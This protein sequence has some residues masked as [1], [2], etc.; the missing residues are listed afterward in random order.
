MTK[1]KKKP[2][3]QEPLTPPN[4]TGIVTD[5]ETGKGLCGLGVHLW[6]KQGN[7]FQYRVARI[8][9]DK[10]GGFE[11]SVVVDSDWITEFVTDGFPDLYL[12]VFNGD[13]LVGCA[14]RTWESTVEGADVSIELEGVTPNPEDCEEDGDAD[15][16]DDE[17]DN[18]DD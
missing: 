11:F 16:C 2:K 5:K 14:H 6:V 17:H 7:Q 15:D 13:E 1:S 3:E 10:E 4:I 9:T 12:K 18:G 8:K